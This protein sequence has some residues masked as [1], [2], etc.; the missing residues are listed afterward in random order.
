MRNHRATTVG[1]AIVTGV[2]VIFSISGCGGGATGGTLAS[3]ASL[4]NYHS[5]EEWISLIDQAGLTEYAALGREL[6]AQ[7]RIR[8]VSPPLLDAR[9]NAFSFLTDREVWIN[10]PLFTR[11]PS[12]VDQTTIFLHELIHIAHN[13]A[14]HNGSWWSAQDQ[15]TNYWR[16][17]PVTP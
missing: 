5:P 17:H 7:G 8:L 6:S 2:V 16:D 15:F 11:Y 3:D 9:F 14:S 10:T 13:E 12:L 1:L 4:P